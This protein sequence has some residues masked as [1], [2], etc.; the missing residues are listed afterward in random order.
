MAKQLLLVGDSNVR[1]Y[2]DHLSGLVGSEVDF[3]QARND[4]E[5]QEAIPS[6][7]KG[8]KIVTYS[9][10]TNII[11]N[12]AHAIADKTAASGGRGQITVSTRQEGEDIV[13]AISDT[14][15][16]V[17]MAVRER[18][19]D[20]FFTT[21]EVGKGTGQGLA[22]AYDIVVNKHGGS[23]TFDSVEGQ[24]STFYVRIPLNS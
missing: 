16:G 4:T 20:P 9:I 11:I 2:F 3:V 13:I 6:C 7:K 15:S 14:G 17:P 10:L 1:R 22:I 5:W 18:I 23:L 8:Y 19:F 12:A 21:K 24:G